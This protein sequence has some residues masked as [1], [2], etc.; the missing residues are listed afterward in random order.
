[1]KNNIKILKDLKNH[2]VKNFGDN[3]KD[4]ILFG[5]QITG[6]ANENSDYDV[7]ILLKNRYNWKYWNKLIDAVN[8]KEYEL[9]FDIMFDTHILSNYEIKYSLKGQEPIY[10]NALNTGI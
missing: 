1:M 6:K 9:N 8:D 4:V 3:I 7:L 5:S 2:L 10:I